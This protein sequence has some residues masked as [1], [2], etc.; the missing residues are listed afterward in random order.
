MEYFPGTKDRTL[1][2]SG[3]LRQI[4]AALY[5]IFIRL[6][7]EDV[8][9]TDVKHKKDDLSDDNEELGNHEVDWDSPSKVKLFVKMLVPQELCGIIVGKSGST[10]K[11]CS[12]VSHASVKISPVQYGGLELTH[13]I[14]CI[15][16]ELTNIMKAVAMVILKQAEDPNFRSY[17]SIP[18]SYYM[19]D[20]K[21]ESYRESRQ[22]FHYPQGIVPFASTLPTYSSYHLPAYT[23]IVY[24]LSEEQRLVLYGNNREG[25]SEV[26]RVARVQTSLEQGPTPHVTL[27]RVCGTVEGVTCAHGLMSQKLA[28]H[29]QPDNSTLP[30]SSHM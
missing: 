15:N 24:P 28:S 29:Y 27:L 20:T 14:V 16:G 17:G 5:A 9:P 26:E 11:H 21:S 12:A 3:T 23:S 8:A 7:K 4:I 13:K 19:K 22:S 25:M 2:V 6:I 18:A 1:L 10:I 30:G